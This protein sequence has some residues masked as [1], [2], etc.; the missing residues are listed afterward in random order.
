MKQFLKRIFIVRGAQNPPAHRV[1]LPRNVI[2]SILASLVEIIFIPVLVE[3]FKVYYVVAV[4]SCMLVA[5]TMSFFLNKYWVFEAHQGDVPKQYLKQIIVAAGSYIFNISL[6]LLFTEKLHL[7]YYLSFLASNV[8]VFLG[9]NY[10]VSRWF[11]FSDGHNS[12]K[13]HSESSP[14]PNCAESD[15]PEKED[16]KLPKKQFTVVL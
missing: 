12:P 8:L 2:A 13:Q 3:F 14:P 11:V 4:A 16:E 15:K 10:P 5:T 6:I 1:S 9:W 7:Y